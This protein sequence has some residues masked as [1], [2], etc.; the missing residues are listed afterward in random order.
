MTAYAAAWAAMTRTAAEAALVTTR[1]YEL[2]AIADYVREHYS[3]PQPAS[4]G[5]EDGEAIR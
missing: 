5:P 3:L 4:T 1:D 2:L